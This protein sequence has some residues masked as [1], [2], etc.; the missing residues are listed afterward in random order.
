MEVARK[1]KNNDTFKKYVV[2]V[3]VLVAICFVISAAL[4]LT[5]GVADPIIKRNTKAE[6]DKAR[7]ELLAKADT[8]DKYEGKLLATSD[9]KVTV[10]EAYIAKNGEGM[11]FTV[12]T[13]S[14]GGG[15]IEMIGIDKNGEITGVVIQDHKDTPGVGTKAFTADHLKQYKGVKE[16]KDTSAKKDPTINHITGA[17][18]SSNAVH[19][20]VYE[21]LL[22]YKEIGGA[23]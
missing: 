5:Y 16:L 3:I 18:V 20:G 1:M 4:A 6:A 9:G 21:A 2:P 10:K 14:F 22:Q 15:L 11:V 7:K 8:F 12:E 17:S 23:K 13:K 19:Y